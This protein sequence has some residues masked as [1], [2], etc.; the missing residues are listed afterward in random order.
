LL[1]SNDQKLKT[2]EGDNNT[3]YF[4]LIA[5]G[6]HRKTRIFQLEGNNKIIKNEVELKEHITSY[7]QNLF[8][9]PE[10][11][12][13]T[14]LES[15][16]DDIPQVSEVENDIL[17]SLFTKTEVK[18]AIFQ[19]EHNKAP[20]PD[21]FPVEFYQVFWEVIK[22]DLMA[23]FHDFHKGELPLFSLN[24][25]IITLLPKFQEAIKIQ[26]Y[27]PICLLNVSFKIFTKVA[28][29]RKNLVAQKVI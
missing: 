19:M 21:G 18:E 26:Q 8:G 28:T 4:H 29:N 11:N 24:F 3:K 25:G 17:T 27:R 5:N 6:K 1:G 13:F 10:E 9:A 7:Y 15:R 20:G 16:I 23:L 14:M 22:A 12:N 2:L